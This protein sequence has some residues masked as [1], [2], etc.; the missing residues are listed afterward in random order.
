MSEICNLNKRNVLLISLFF[1]FSMITLNN[2][3]AQSQREKKDHDFDNKSLNFGVGYSYSF[4]EPHNKKFHL[5][6]LEINRT[7]HNG[8]AGYQYGGGTEIVLNT[9]KF[10]IAPKINGI[11]NYQFLVL[12]AELVSYTNF[13]NGNL[14]FVP[15]IGIG[16]EK[17][18]FT[19]N[20]Q[21]NIL[22]K[23]YQPVN[24]G[25][26]NLTINLNLQKI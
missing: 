7:K 22:N 18:R 17:F 1:I 5:I 14:R 13:E 26:L 2:V 3:N 21:I 10:T 24:K 8:V 25:F 4:A 16:L 6:N 15:M 19:I 9:E 12:G 23:N 20:P 11:I